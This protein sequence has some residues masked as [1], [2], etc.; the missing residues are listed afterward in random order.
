MRI[1]IAATSNV[2]IPS[3]IALK[4]S[5][6]TVVLATQPDKPTG[7]GLKMLPSPVSAEFPETIRIDNEEQLQDLLVGIDLLITIGFGRILSTKTLSIPKYGGINLH[8]SLLPKWRG[9]A[10]VQRAIEFGDPETG[11]T[12]FQMDAGMDTGPIWVQKN[13]RI[14]DESL[15][16]EVFEQLSLI[17]SD[18]LLAAI[19]MIE[20]GKSPLPQIGKSSVAAKIDKT[21]A[22]IDWS[23]NSETI[24]RKIKAF[25]VSPICRGLFR[26]QIVK[27]LD[28][29]L[30]NE[31]LEIG[32]LN[33][34]G[35]VGCG[36]GSI[37]LLSVLPAG[38]KEMSAKA[39]ING[40]NLKVGEKFEF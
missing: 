6:H 20:V 37:K 25:S 3:I 30:S 11:V 2:A 4:Q 28:A 16:S 26:G 38:K 29:A 9:A 33:E 21:E 24:I 18:A 35:E 15:A 10:P 40:L 1:L 27:I 23:L 12:V 13:C 17:G 22:V 7:R 34:S 5:K 31:S 19:D 39:W 36:S 32:Q 14:K 8:F